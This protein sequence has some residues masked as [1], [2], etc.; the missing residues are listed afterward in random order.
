MTDER[1]NSTNYPVREGRTFGYRDD[2]CKCTLTVQ[3]IVVCLI[4]AV[5]GIIIGRDVMS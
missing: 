5:N 1:M 2:A 3:K 4:I